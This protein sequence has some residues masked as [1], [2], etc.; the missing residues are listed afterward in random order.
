M[1]GL[2]ERWMDEWVGRLVFA[3]GFFRY[4]HCR[5]VKEEGRKIKVIFVDK[6]VGP[7]K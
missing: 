2:E 7:R 6:K 3:V 1:G 4:T 5:W